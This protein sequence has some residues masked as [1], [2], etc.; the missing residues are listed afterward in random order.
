MTTTTHER[1]PVATKPTND[2]QRPQMD[3]VHVTWSPE[4]RIQSQLPGK[5]CGRHDKEDDDDNGVVI[6]LYWINAVSTPA[7]YCPPTQLMRHS[8]H[9]L[10]NGSRWLAHSLHPSPTEWHQTP[11]TQYRRMTDTDE[12][13]WMNDNRGPTD[14]RQQG[15]PMTTRRHQH[16]PPWMAMRALPTNSLPPPSLQICPCSLLIAPPSLW[17]RA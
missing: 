7:R 6:I 10:P 9:R 3:N 5:R 4:L 2:H 8:H 13:Q 17:Y 12:Q 16:L 11:T 15:Q 1:G 14:N